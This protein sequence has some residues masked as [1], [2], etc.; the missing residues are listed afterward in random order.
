LNKTGPGESILMMMAKISIGSAR[1]KIPKNDKRISINLFTKC[2]YITPHIPQSKLHAESSAT[3]YF[4]F[5]RALYVGS[6]FP[7][8][9][10]SGGREIMGVDS[11]RSA[12]FGEHSVSG[13]I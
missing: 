2:L 4:S 12:D 3:E 8:K 13:F 7:G 9:N 5:S 11:C 10:A 1:T 6:D